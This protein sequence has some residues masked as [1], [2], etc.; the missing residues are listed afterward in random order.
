MSPPRAALAVLAVLSVPGVFHGWC[1]LGSLLGQWNPLCP[2]VDCCLLLFIKV[3]S[4]LIRVSPG[5]PQ[6]AF[7]CLSLSQNMTAFWEGGF[8]LG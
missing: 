5:E 3:H 2:L 4:V 8:C 7:P 1:L 6:S